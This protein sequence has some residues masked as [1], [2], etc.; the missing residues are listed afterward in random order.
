MSNYNNVEF[1]LKKTLNYNETST[2]IH[3][4]RQ[5]TQAHSPM[6]NAIIYI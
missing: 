3:S 2:L 4:F 6:L 5:I 1:E